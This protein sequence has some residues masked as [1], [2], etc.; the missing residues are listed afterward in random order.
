M[1][2]R[3]V[4][5]VRAALRVRVGVVAVAAASLIP[6][7]LDGQWTNRYPKIAGLSHHVY[8]EGY[9]LPA[10]TNGP[11]DVAPA[12]DGARLAFA[13]RGWIWIWDP[14]DGIARRLT[15]G[16]DLDS[17]PAWSPDGGRIALVRDD[18]SDTRIVIVDASTG[19]D[20][21]TID[22][23]AIDLDPTFAGEGQLLH[24]SAESGDLDLWHHVLATGERR[25]LTNAR[26]QELAPAYSPRGILYLSKGGTDRVRWVRSV[27]PGDG[28]ILRSGGSTGGQAVDIGGEEIASGSITSQTRPALSPDGSLVALNWP[29]EDGWELRLHGVD[30]PGPFVRLVADALPLAPAWGPEGEWIYYSQA[31]DAERMRLY[32]VARGGGPPEEIAIRGWSW[33]EPTATVR[34]RTRTPA[35]GLAEARLEVRDGQGH[36]AVPDPGAARFDGQNGRVFFYSDGSIDVVVPAGQVT[37][38]AVRGLATPEVRRTV[39]ANAGQVTEVDL[40]LE[41]VWTGADWVS[42]EHHFHLNYGG[43]YDLSPSDLV[44]MMRG[45]ALDVATP[46]L[47]NLHTRFE[48]QDLWEWDRSGEGPLIRFG[49]EIRSHFLGHLGLVDAQELFWPWVWGPRYEVYGTDDRENAEA[50]A[51]ARARGGI[52]YYVHPVS[53]SDPFSPDGMSA[54]PIELVADAV[55]GDLDAIEVVCVWSDEIGTA[56]VWHRFLNLGIPVAPSAGTDVMTDFYRTM[57]VGTTRV[58]ARTGGA[59]DWASYLGAL[60]SGRTFVTNGPLLDFAVEGAGP[61]GVV[62]AGSASW[63]LSVATASEVEQVEILVNGEVVWS[64]EGLSAAGAR[65]FEGSLDLPGGGW[66]AARA[67]G[68]ETRWPSMD[69]YPY[70]HTAPVWIGEVGSTESVARRRAAGELLEVLAVARERLIAGYGD[71]GIPNL[72]ARFE[73]ARERLEALA[74][75]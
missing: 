71:A 52:G 18:G 61:G 75:D 56:E 32:R 30:D 63:T 73:R 15:T 59:L 50:L 8:L 62:D 42:G 26:G 14:A 36:P 57:A 3:P 51:H 48:D 68:G 70:A 17:R 9:E 65:S 5:T 27:T 12:P 45:E 67:A 44:P 47:A 2:A 58:Y 1:T 41:T 21:E 33:G 13:A 28:V 29:T 66:V 10:L 39:Q 35:A 69:S 25:P 40:T 23:P 43:I 31:D 49:Q 37:V 24:S 74:R 60:G 20:L 22:T 34:V 53:V 16:G 64:G 46:L 19:A 4:A 54:V 7:A 72:L 55:L 38:S 6:A 11:M